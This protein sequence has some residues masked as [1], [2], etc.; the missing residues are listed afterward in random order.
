MDEAAVRLHL[1]RLEKPLHYATR[2]NFAHLPSAGP[3]DLRPT[4]RPGSAGPGAAG[5]IDSIA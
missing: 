1:E 2:N 3:G 5:A 4:S